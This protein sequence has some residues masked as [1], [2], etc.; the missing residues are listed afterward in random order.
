VWQKLRSLTLEEVQLE[1][2][3]RVGFLAPSDYERLQEMVEEVG[4][5]LNG[6]IGSMQPAES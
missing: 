2:A 3:K 4:R 5:M 1:I 6:L